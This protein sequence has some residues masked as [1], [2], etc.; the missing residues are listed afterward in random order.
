MAALV[1]NRIPNEISNIVEALNIAN[2]KLISKYGTASGSPVHVATREG[3]ANTV[4][5]YKKQYG[6]KMI[7]YAVR[8][9]KDPSFKIKGDG[10]YQKIHASLLPDYKA[11]SS[12]PDVTKR[13]EEF[14]NE[15]KESEENWLLADEKGLSPELY[16]YGYIKQGNNLV[17]CTISEA[18]N[19]DLDGFIRT[20]GFGN[21]EMQKNITGQL[22][23]LFNEMAKDMTMIC[24][25]IKPQNT[26]IKFEQDPNGNPI[27]NENFIIK[28][29]D[30][31]ADWCRDYKPL[32]SR[33][34]VAGPA[35]QQAAATIMIMVMANFFFM[36]YRNNILMEH[37]K[38]FYDTDSNQGF[39][40][41]KVMMNLF[42]AGILSGVN[43]TEFSFMA[44]HYFRMDFRTDG[45]DQS[46]FLT[47]MFKR[48]LCKNQDDYESRASSI[49]LTLRGGKKKKRKTRRKYNRKTKKHNKHKKKQ[50]KSR[51]KKKSSKRKTKKYN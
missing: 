44:S 18:F 11:Q 3:S 50:P 21:A 36:Y 41:T 32:R 25:D 38:L 27:L 15:T 1:D 26:V 37:M 10:Y 43:T 29:I 9:G 14:L 51:I 24:F 40:I 2:R 12:I 42:E 28:L 34:Q 4:D 19:M 5:V 48:S 33:D 22:V 47:E 6:G 8:M 49:E 17:L 39:M 46:K 20:H 13:R 30:W 31:D 16:F 7:T 23:N 35:N 45:G